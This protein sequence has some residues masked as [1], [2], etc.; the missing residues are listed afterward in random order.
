MRYIFY[1][2]FSLVLL[3][4]SLFAAGLHLPGVGAK[5]ISMGGAFRAIADDP[6]AIYWNPA[7]ISFIGNNELLLTGQFLYDDFS[8]TPNETMLNTAHVVREG[9]QKL[10]SNTFILGHL[11]SSFGVR[12]LEN[13]RF[14]MGVYSPLGVG[15]T[16]DIM[17]DDDLDYIAVFNSIP[18]TTTETLPENDF[19]GT[20]GAYTFS[21]TISYKPVE[22]LS[23]GVGLL[24]TY[25]QIDVAMPVTDSTQM[26][27]DTGLIFEEAE[28]S[29]MSWG[30]N[31]GILYK[32]TTRFSAG[33]S[34]KW[35]TP[36]KYSGDY[37]ETVYKFYNEDFAFLLPGGLTV[38]DKIDA[39][40]D[41]KRPICTGLGV[42]YKPVNNLT[43]SLDLSYTHWSIID[44]VELK[45]TDNDSTLEKLK[46]NWDNCFR[47]SGGLEYRLS[48]YAIRAGLFYEPHPP[49]PEYQNL[50]LMDFND[51]VALSLGFA[52]YFRKLVIEI[53][54]EY[55]FF[56]DKE[57]E[58]Y[59][60]ENALVNIPGIYG[61]FVA[62][63]TLSFK[64]IF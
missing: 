59:Y 57:F 29:G 40:I 30:L 32:P 48:R 39:Q 41:L 33:F 58:D 36:I 42:A 1:F 14:G 52:A 49:T 64:Y 7:G 47:V 50:F 24:S 20:I 55:E 54:G 13:F 4:S 16:W 62:D 53:S 31:F 37:L 15:S 10:K 45:T 56:K 3:T 26:L 63:L 23:F 21:P 34:F 22:E 44:S 9:E 5:G 12:A 2:S 46:L 27:A 28:M 11:F 60:E 18:L 61:G 6:S 38:K 17:K 19:I 25:S 8:Y 43:L 51:N 35:E